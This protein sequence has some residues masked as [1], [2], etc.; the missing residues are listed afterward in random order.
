MPANKKEAVTGEEGVVEGD[1]ERLGRTI[2]G[3]VTRVL[4]V[5]DV[6]RREH[7]GLRPGAKDRRKGVWRVHQGAAGQLQLQRL[8][9]ARRTL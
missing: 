8:P 2:A 9:Q 7:G 4:S 1:D 6:V 5:E 3:L